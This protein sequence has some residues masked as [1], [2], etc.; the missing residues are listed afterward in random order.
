V[1]KRRFAKQ[2]VAYLGARSAPLILADAPW[3]LRNRFRYRLYR[4]PPEA[5]QG[6]PG[7]P[8]DGR[9]ARQHETE[10][11]AR[12]TQEYVVD[13]TWDCHVRPFGL[14]P[15]VE[16]LFVHEL[17]MEATRTYNQMVTAMRDGDAITARG[18][19]SLGDVKD[20]F[21][22]IH[23]TYDAIRRQGYHRQVRLFRPPGD[24]ITLCVGRS[25]QLLLLRHGNHRVSYAKL[26]KVPLVP[27]IV[28]GVHREWARSLVER[29]PT[30]HL[31]HILE[32][33]LDELVAG[34][35][36]IADRNAR[37]EGL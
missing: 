16:D 34:L 22:E 8:A 33:G 23:A 32:R 12:M 5:I 7:I 11:L 27:V 6:K 31:V 28:R 35:R 18:C 26:L 1:S 30:G 2:Y 20:H 17:P 36:H 19:R 13:G 9:S 15:V 14:H 3:V 4:V 29:Y 24:E 25:G 10:L 37:D 21:N